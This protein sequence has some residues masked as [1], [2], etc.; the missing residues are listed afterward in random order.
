MLSDQQ[1]HEELEDK[2]ILEE[3][4]LDE[5]N[6]LNELLEVDELELSLEYD[7][8]DLDFED[9]Q[10]DSLIWLAQL[11]EL[12]DDLDCSE[13]EDEEVL[14][15]PELQLLLRLLELQLLLLLLSLF[16]LDDE[17]SLTNDEDNELL[18][19]LFDISLRHEEEQE[20]HEK[21]SITE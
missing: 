16:E 7:P 5:E 6:G 15:D 12:L 20:E 4:W 14:D 3:H 19:Q 21:C 9:E 10:L 11:L 2:D 18:E 17:L 13:A 8:Q 1:L